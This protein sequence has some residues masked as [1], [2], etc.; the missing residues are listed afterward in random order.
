MEKYMCRIL[1]E[2]GATAAESLFA[3]QQNAYHT[4]YS[5]ELIALLLIK[6]S[7]LSGVP[8]LDTSLP[9]CK[10]EKHFK[11][12]VFVCLK[13]YHSFNRF[14]GNGNT[15][16]GR[17]VGVFPFPSKRLKISGFYVYRLL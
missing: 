1:G 3:E 13:S 8:Y 5:E 2:C 16:K 12:C 14:D 11:H 15:M 17:K 7:S 4:L 10:Q 9:K 6:R